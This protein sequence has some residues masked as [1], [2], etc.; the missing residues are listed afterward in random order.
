MDKL[1]ALHHS[2]YNETKGFGNLQEQFKEAKKLNPDITL[3]DV[4]NW[5]NKNIEKNK[6]IKRI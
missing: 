3:D 5:R 2:Y 4:K 1:D 6:T